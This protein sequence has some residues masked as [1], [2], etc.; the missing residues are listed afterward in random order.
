MIHDLLF[1][2]VSVLRVFARL[3]LYQ[4]K[5]DDKDDKDERDEQNDKELKM[6]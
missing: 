3:V 1:A 5:K 2:G 6:F 4:N